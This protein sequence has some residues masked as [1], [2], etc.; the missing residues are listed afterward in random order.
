MLDKVLGIIEIVEF[1]TKQCFIWI[2]YID[3][4]MAQFFFFDSSLW[5]R[6][7]FFTGVEAFFGGVFEAVA[8]ADFVILLMMI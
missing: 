8:D 2:C 5:G 7:V 4:L 1:P 6:A 3:N